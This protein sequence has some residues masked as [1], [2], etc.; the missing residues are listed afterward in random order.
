MGRSTKAWGME[1]PASVSKLERHLW[2][3]A[4]D[5]RS[6][7]AGGPDEEEKWLAFKACVDLLWNCEGSTRR[8]IWNDWTEQMLRA[9]VKYRYVGLAGCGSSGKSDSAAVFALVEWLAG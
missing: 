8:V 2:R 5:K 9:M 4:H 7:E 6:P 3:Y 1:F